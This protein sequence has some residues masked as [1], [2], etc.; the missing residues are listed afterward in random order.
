MIYNHQFKGKQHTVTIYKKMQNGGHVWRYIY[1]Q[2]KELFF[3][4]R[5][6]ESFLGALNEKVT[7][8][9]YWHLWF[10]ILKWGEIEL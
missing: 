8:S 7:A 1:M 5:D 3:V 10:Y 4:K 6:L 2:N 9:T